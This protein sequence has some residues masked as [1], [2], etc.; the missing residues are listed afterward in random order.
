[1]V[2]APGKRPSPALFDII[3]PHTDLPLEAHPVIVYDFGSH[4][5]QLLVRKKSGMERDELLQVDENAAA[6]GTPDAE[7]T[8]NDD[9]ALRSYWNSMLNMMGKDDNELDEKRQAAGD[10]TNQAEVTDAG[11]ARARLTERSGETIHVFSVA[12]GYLYERFVKIMMLSVLKRT[13]NPVTFWLL[14]NFL[15]PDFKASI[16]VL[17]EQFGMDI[18]LVTYKWP[19]WLRQ[20]TEKQRIIWGYKILFLDVLFPLGVQKVIYV[21]ADQVV[22][23][24]LKE[25]LELDMEGK[26]Y[27]YTPFC[28]SRNVGFQFW[29]QGYWKDHLRGKPYHI[30][31]LYVVDLAVFRRMAAGDILRATYSQLS[32]DPN[33]LA[34]LDQDLPNY[35]QSQI[36]IFSLPQEWLWCESWCS[37]ETKAAA[38]TIDLCNNPKHKEPKLDMAKRIIAGEL[39][40]ES[41]IEL[42]QEIK[43]MEAHYAA[44]S[45]M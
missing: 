9:G 27:G 8:D 12:S 33:S 36:P 24:D 31:A 5:V 22:R 26:P 16:P 21:D 25:L 6:A 19:N 1:M 18:R 40:N 45:A 34:N 14:E 44:R 35:V 10:G 13:N 3:D 11:S 43:D 28:G 7:P 41:W 30:S 2:L 42:D 29:R 23:A 39:F 17:R 4:I 38:K 37:D 15:S 20:Q 32:A